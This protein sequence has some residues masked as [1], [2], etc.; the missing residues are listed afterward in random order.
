MKPFKIAIEKY[1]M[2]MW[3]IQLVF[4]GFPLGKG[5]PMKKP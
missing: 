2:A 5:K 1:Q 4:L 3:P